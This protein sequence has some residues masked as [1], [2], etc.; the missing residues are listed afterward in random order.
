MA[1]VAAGLLH[2]RRRVHGVAEKC[3]L[4]LGYAELA[5]DDRSAMQRRAEIGAA[6]KVANVV[7]GKRV[8]FRQRV[9]AGAHAVSARMPA[10]SGQVTMISSPTYLW[11]VP[12]CA[13]IGPVTSAIKRLRKS[14]KPVSPR[15]SAMAVEDSISM[16]SSTHSS[17]RGRR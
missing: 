16:N 10:A 4:H 11:M 17:M 14:R 7:V 2:S 15:R 9:K 8:E 13:T 5:D 3:D 1:G 12:S 6:A